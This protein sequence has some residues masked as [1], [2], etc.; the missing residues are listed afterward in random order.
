[1]RLVFIIQIYIFYNM[2]LWQCQYVDVNMLWYRGMVVISTAQLHSTN[3]EVRLCAGS[4]PAR[5]VS[6]IRDGEDL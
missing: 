5:D 6:E 4:D 2:C 1:M 3:P